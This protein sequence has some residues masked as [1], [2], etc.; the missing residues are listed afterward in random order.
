MAYRPNRAVI[1][2]HG[3]G[4]RSFPITTFHG[5]SPRLAGMGA[6]LSG[7]AAAPK[8]GT[9]AARFSSGGGGGG[10]QPIDITCPEGFTLECTQKGGAFNCVCRCREGEEVYGNPPLCTMDEITSPV[11][12]PSGATGPGRFRGRAAAPKPGMW[13]ARF[14]R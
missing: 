11:V 12:K 6:R 1:D 8:P 7:R 10:V 2:Q 5:S 13:A 4:R 14:N 3:V 9:W